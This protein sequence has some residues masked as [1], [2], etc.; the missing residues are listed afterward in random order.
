MK[1][2]QPGEA[3]ESPERT[4]TPQ[5]ANSGDSFRVELNGGSLEYS[6]F[7]NRYW[8]IKDNFKSMAIRQEFFSGGRRM[9]YNNFW[10]NFAV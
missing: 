6:H 3:G 2:T 8:T 4:T 7:V 5:I 10:I 1:E 9:G